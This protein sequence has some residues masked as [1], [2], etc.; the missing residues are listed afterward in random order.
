MNKNSS[1]NFEQNFEKNFNEYKNHISN[2]VFKNNS[3]NIRGLLIGELP[4]INNNHRHLYPVHSNSN[5][6]SIKKHFEM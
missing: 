5:L 1:K 6:L 4:E 3:S 2:P